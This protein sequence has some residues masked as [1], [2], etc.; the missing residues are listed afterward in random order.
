MKNFDYPVGIS[1][2][3]LVLT[4]FGAGFFFGSSTLGSALSGFV[5]SI[6]SSYVFFFLTVSLKDRA[7][8]KKIKNIVNP[9][10]GRIVSSVYVAIHNSVLYPNKSCRPMPDA[11]QLSLEDLT[12]LLDFNSLNIPL[13]GFRSHY[14]QFDI[15]AETYID[16]LILDTTLPIESQ[17]EQIK[18]YYYMLEHDVV[19]ILTDIEGAMYLCFSGQRLKHDKSFVFDK[20]LFLDFWK[21]IKKLDHHVEAKWL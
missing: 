12:E 15:K 13:K 11:S 18:P 14:P 17:L 3:A 1:F 7:D 5:L 8:K 9:K 16:Q 21:Q 4:C 19:K 6:F 20:E 2:V 10:L